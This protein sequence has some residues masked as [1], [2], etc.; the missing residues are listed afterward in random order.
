MVTQRSDQRR[1]EE[2]AELH[3]YLTD[4]AHGLGWEPVLDDCDR[5]LPFAGAAIE[6]TAEVVAA[7]AREG[8][9]F[10][11]EGVVT[12]EVAEDVA[13]ALRGAAVLAGTSGSAR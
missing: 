13:L 4:P 10:G 7:C 3:R 11:R 2:S 9:A 6:I 1:R 12:A 5:P 8:A